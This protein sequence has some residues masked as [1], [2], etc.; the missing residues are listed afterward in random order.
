MTTDDHPTG[1]DPL[2]DASHDAQIE[3]LRAFVREHPTPPRV[4]DLGAGDGRL[5]APL[6]EMGC[7]LTAIERDPRAVNALRGR[8]IEAHLWDFLAHENA[9]IAPAAHDIALCM[10]NTLCLVH[11]PDDA[12]RLMKRIR[13][14]LDETGVLIIDDI[15]TETWRDVASGDWQTGLSEDGSMQLLWADG[16]NVVALRDGENVNTDDWT[17]RPSDTPMRLWSRG[18]LTLLARASGFDGPRTSPGGTL[19]LF[20]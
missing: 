7:T 11:D 16:D 17:I 10:G 19:I 8:G 15:L 20:S 6:A 3:E 5:A 13:T 9:P 4:L 2:D 14:W 12:L 1:W 18:E